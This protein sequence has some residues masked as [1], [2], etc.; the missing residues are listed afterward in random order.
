MSIIRR[1]K[2]SGKGDEWHL[3]NPLFYRPNIF[4]AVKET[5][6]T[7]MTGRIYHFTTR[8]IRG[9][10]NIV[11]SFYE[12]STNL[13]TSLTVTKSGH[14]YAVEG[15]IRTKATGD[16]RDITGYVKSIPQKKRAPKDVRKTSVPAKV[17]RILMTL[18]RLEEEVKSLKRHLD[19]PSPSTIPFL[20]DFVGR[21]VVDIKPIIIQTLA[22]DAQIV[23]SRNNCFGD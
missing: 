17:S 23:Y 18:S 8:N 20:P 11:R 13:E 16:V 12:E 6:P 10:N 5:F 7:E 22:S 19:S 21:L 15:T 1:S 3:I 14:T 4:R 9:K 2:K